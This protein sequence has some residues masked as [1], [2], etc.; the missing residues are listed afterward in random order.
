M[1]VPVVGIIAFCISKYFYKNSIK[2]FKGIFNT[3]FLGVNILGLVFA[4]SYKLKTLFG[5]LGFTNILINKIVF[6]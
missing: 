3:G 1:A 2:S 4:K 5:G 6:K